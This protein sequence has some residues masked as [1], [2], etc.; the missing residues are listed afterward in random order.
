MLQAHRIAII[1]LLTMMQSFSPLVHAHLGGLQSAGAIHLPGLEFL[2]GAQ[3]NQAQSSDGQGHM[4]E[5]I[6]VPATGHRDKAMLAAASPDPVFDLPNNP[7]PA[8]LPP[9]FRIAAGRGP[10]IV[11]NRPLWLKP[12]PRA[13]PFLG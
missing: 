12:S 5:V 8:A 13:P 1:I 4:E 6:V 10:D 9:S 3:E 7:V 2:S 11:Q